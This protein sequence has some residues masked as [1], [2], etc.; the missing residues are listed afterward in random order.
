MLNTVNVI[1]W[2][3]D[4]I[5]RITSFADDKKGNEQAEKLFTDL[6]EENGFSIDDVD[7]GLEDGHLERDDYE[8]FLVHSTN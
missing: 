6:A 8:L 1:E 2:F 4:T 5:Q 7:K 3:S